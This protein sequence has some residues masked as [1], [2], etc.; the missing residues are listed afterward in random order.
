MPT[1]NDI[2]N[3]VI[4]NTMNQSDIL[5]QNLGNFSAVNDINS[6]ENEEYNSQ[7]NRGT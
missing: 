5:S 2:N 6:T 1:I 4:N 7:N 3:N